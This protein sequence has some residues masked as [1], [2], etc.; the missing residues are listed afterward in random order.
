MYMTVFASVTITFSFTASAK[1]AHP[2]THPA[3]EM[4]PSNYVMM[5]QRHKVGR[6]LMSILA[7]GHLDCL[8][9]SGILVVNSSYNYH[10]IATCQETCPGNLNNQKNNPGSIE[11]QCFSNFCSGFYDPGI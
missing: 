4:F 11:E 10:M 9:D 7:G 2:H 5:L 1:R 8:L 3:P 6:I